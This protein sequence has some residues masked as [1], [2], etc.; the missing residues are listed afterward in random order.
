MSSDGINKTYSDIYFKI[1]NNS[2]N[3]CIFN[4]YKTETQLYNFFLFLLLYVRTRP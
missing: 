3:L 4:R 2:Y 1:Y